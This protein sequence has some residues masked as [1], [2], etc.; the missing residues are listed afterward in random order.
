MRRI[1]VM[2]SSKYQASKLQVILKYSFCFLWCKNYKNRPTNARVIVENNFF[3]G[4]GVYYRNHKRGKSFKG[5][6]AVFRPQSI[7]RKNDS[8][9]HGVHRLD[10]AHI[11]AVMTVHAV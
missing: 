4:H 5:A 7:A 1:A 6:P 2:T 10:G 11:Q 9:L 8:V 3:S